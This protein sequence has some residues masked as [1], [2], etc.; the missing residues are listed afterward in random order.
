MPDSVGLNYYVPDNNIPHGL[1][2]KED[3]ISKQSIKYYECC[4]VSIIQKG[5]L[6][7]GSPWIIPFC[8]SSLKSDYMKVLTELLPTLHDRKYKQAR[9]TLHKN[10]HFTAV[11][12]WHGSKY[13]YNVLQLSN[14][15][16]LRPLK[17][18]DIKR[19]EN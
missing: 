9:F 12:F 5:N 4:G 17:A 1:N 13:F 10:A 7:S 2:S 3:I 14:L 16:Y 18:V 19:Q 8:I 15:T 6:V 11:I